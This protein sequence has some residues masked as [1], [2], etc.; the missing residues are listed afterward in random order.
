M[1]DRIELASQF[2]GF[3][4]KRKVDELQKLIKINPLKNQWCAAFVTAI[5]K[6]AGQSGTG[7]LAA[8]AYLN[9]GTRVQNPKPGDIVVL[10]RG[11][12]DSCEGHVGYLIEKGVT[13]V[14]ILGGNQDHQVKIKKYPRERVL[15]YVRIGDPDL[16]KP[17]LSV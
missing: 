15:G 9:Y 13:S 14:T 2:I 4:E 11:A 12:R 7:V 16:P 6:L 8:R 10:W 1:Q 3:S 17:L 5:E